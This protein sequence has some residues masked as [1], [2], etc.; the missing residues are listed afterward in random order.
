MNN[1]HPLFV[2]FPIA[3]FTVYALLEMIP[4]KKLRNN[5][6][7]FLI[8]CFIL[9]IGTVSVWP[10]LAS[11]EAIEHMF[12]SDASKNALVEIHGLWGSVAAGIFQGLAAVYLIE[13]I[14]K[15]KGKLLNWLTTQKGVSSIWKLLNWI[16]TKLYHK[17]VLIIFALLGFIALTCA[18]ALG[19]ALVHGEQIDPAVQFIY[20]LHKPFL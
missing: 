19:A 10:T 9:I 4:S 6:T 17:P 11:G 13:W 3:L 8:K 12:G 1:L 5:E 18:G 7:V 20:N 14:K 15:G 2:H 16:Q